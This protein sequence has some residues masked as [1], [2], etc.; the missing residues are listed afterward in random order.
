[1]K[2][3][4]RTLTRSI[5]RPFKAVEERFLP[6]RVFTRIYE[7]GRWNSGGTPSGAGS[8]MEQTA[9]IR[10]QLPEL[11]ERHG[12]RSMVDVPCGDF[13]WIGTLDYRFDRYVG[14]DIVES[15]VERNRQRHSAPER[16]F[17]RLDIITDSLPRADVVLCRDCW[18]HLSTPQIQRAIRNV[19]RSDCTY[20]LT[21]T[22]TE[23][24]RNADIAT[25][26]WRPINLREAPFSFPE[27]LEVIP[28]GAVGATGEFSDKS[29]ALWRISDLRR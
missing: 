2:K 12:I 17:Q 13:N 25:G 24:K 8:T 3:L 23:V 26:N 11:L 6:G 20:L 19:A 5:K 27:P 1:M 16:E 18:V 28:D 9:R 14:G 15:L 22:Y 21:T 10:A 29:L 4:I 7:R